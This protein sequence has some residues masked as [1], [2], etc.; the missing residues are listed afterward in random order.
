MGLTNWRLAGLQKNIRN[1]TLPSFKELCSTT[2]S[3]FYSS[4]RGDN[5]AQARYLLYYLQQKGLLEVFYRSFV[6]NAKTDPTGF[7][8]LKKIL[9]TND[10]KAF[11]SQW[12]KWVLDLRFP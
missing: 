6:K 7:E 1:G 4:N 12:E 11:Q 10:M 5:Y 9:N 2:D 8:T 3:Q